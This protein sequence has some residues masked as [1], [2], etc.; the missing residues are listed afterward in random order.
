MAP[1]LPLLIVLVLLFAFGFLVPMLWYAA[2]AVVV[3]WLIWLGVSA[4][5]SAGDRKEVE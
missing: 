5:R 4:I 3:I 2:G 1:V